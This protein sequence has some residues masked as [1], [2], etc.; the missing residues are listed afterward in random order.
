M[1]PDKVTTSELEESLY[2][3]NI[4]GDNVSDATQEETSTPVHCM[5]I[6]FVK[7]KPELCIAAPF[8]SVKNTFNGPSDPSAR[9]NTSETCV[10]D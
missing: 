6:F 5:V 1:S 9:I 3:E 10:Q 7:V 8:P 2:P 4:V